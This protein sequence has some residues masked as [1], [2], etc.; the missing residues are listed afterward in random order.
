MIQ[1]LDPP[2]LLVV[3]RTDWPQLLAEIAY[4][5][6]DP[7]PENPDVREPLSQR[8]LAD[9]L[10]IPRETLRG[11]MDGSEPRHTDGERL[12]AVWVQL[13]GKART[14]IPTTRV[15]FSAARVR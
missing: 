4:L 3:T 7:T 5:L 2:L 1:K 12:I 10:E 11:W 8:L 6:G 13:T 15:S 9:R 14:F